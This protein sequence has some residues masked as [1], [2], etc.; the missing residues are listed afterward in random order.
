M[1]KKPDTSNWNE[2]KPVKSELFHSGLKYEKI[3]SIL[4]INLK[5]TCF[6]ERKDAVKHLGLLG[7]GDNAVI[8]ALN[9]ILSD[10]YEHELI[11]FETA[12]SL[13]LLGDWNE[14][15]CDY[16]KKNLLSSNLNIREELM[17]TIIKS[18]NVQFTDKVKLSQKYFV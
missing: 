8:F 2:V 1:Y 7:V 12:R 10:S 15:V 5:S 9:N 4:S 13:I 6:N 11:K 18:K 17:K 14:N 16:L 3:K